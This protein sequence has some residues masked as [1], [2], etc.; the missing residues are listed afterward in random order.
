MGAHLCRDGRN[1]DGPRSAA[2]DDARDRARPDAGPAA[3]PQLARAEGAHRAGHVR[4]DER[5]CVP[6]ASRARGPHGLLPP[7]GVRHLPVVPAD[8]AR[9]ADGP[10]AFRTRERHRGRR[11]PPRPRARRLR[12]LAGLGPDRP[13]PHVRRRAGHRRHRRAGAHAPGRRWPDARVRH[14]AL[15]RAPARGAAHGRVSRRAERLL[16]HRHRDAGSPQHRRRHRGLRR[17][18]SNLRGPELPARRSSPLP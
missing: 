4:R 11:S 12:A 6:A 2:V 7:A 1:A 9:R 8:D 13:V 17:G 15:A 3:A 16:V 10:R 18:L 5:D 14:R